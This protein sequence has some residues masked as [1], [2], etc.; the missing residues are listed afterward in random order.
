MSDSNNFHGGE[1][2]P[3]YKDDIPSDI[4]DREQWLVAK[5]DKNGKK[6][7]LKPTNPTSIVDGLT[8]EE[9]IQLANEPQT[10]TQISNRLRSNEPTV[11]GFMMSSRDPFAFIDWDDVR[12]PQIGDMSIPDPILTAVS[13]LGSY[14]EISPS[15]TGMKTFVHMDDSLR[16]LLADYGNRINLDL[17]T[18][19]D[20]DAMPHL[21]IYSEKHYTTV[22]ANIFTDPDTNQRFDRIDHGCSDL[23]QFIE[24][25]SADSGL[26]KGSDYDH[27]E[28]CRESESETTVDNRE[29]E[30]AEKGLSLTS[31][32]KRSAHR[33][34]YSSDDKNK[35]WIP[36]DWIELNGKPTVE[37]IR[38][39][40]YALEG[41]FRALWEGNVSGYPTT[42]EADNALV[43]RLWY[44][45][46]DP[47][48]VDRSFRQSQL[49]GIRVRHGERDTPKWDRSSYREATI[50]STQDND[51]YDGRY[52]DP[53]A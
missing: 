6:P 17:K 51:R 14:T 48:L 26:S 34:R 46:G 49:Y 30:K 10:N 52:L 2:R 41:D 8:F 27:T 1:L 39:T 18:V 29:S 3:D 12:D 20:L 47:S 25:N 23:G 21:E 37:Q 31:I 15:G 40:G 33:C 44:Y 42:S 43:S 38:A 32:G 28:N 22:T 4:R 19:G 7:P 45:A 24:T 9:A 11:V 13:S 53:H 16:E 5:I 36:G 50:N 35:E